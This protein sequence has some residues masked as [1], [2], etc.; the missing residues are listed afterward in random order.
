MITRRLSRLFLTLLVGICLYLLLDGSAS[1]CAETFLAEETVTLK[2]ITR[3]MLLFRTQTPDR[4]LPAP[5]QHTDVSM[6]VTGPIVRAVV[7]Q[8]FTNSSATWM[9]G[10]Y[11]FP[12]PD[13]AAVDHLRMQIGER[14]VEGQIQERGEAKRTYERA[15]HHGQRAALVEQDRPNL[16][17]TSVANIAPGETVA[18]TIEYQDTLRPD[19]DT[20]RLRFPMVV[21]PRYIPG[22]PLTPGQSTGNE[23]APAHGLGWTMNTDQVPDA[24][25]VTPPVSPPWEGAINPVRLTIDLAPGFDMDSPI[26]TYHP[27]QADSRESNRWQIRLADGTVPADRDFEL[28]WRP[29]VRTTPTPAMY[30]ENAPDAAYGLMLLTPPSDPGPA[31]SAMPREIIFVIDTSGSMHGASLA[32]AQAALRLALARLAPEDRFN[33]VQFNSVTHRLFREART[34]TPR[35]IAQ[36]LD[37]V[38]GL[39][40]TGGTEML[41]ALTLALDGSAHHDRL[42]QVVFMTDGQAGNEPELFR[43]IQERLGDSRLFTVGIGSAPNSYFMRQAAEFGRGTFTYIGKLDEVQEKMDGLFRKLE[44]P[45]VTDLRIDSAGWQ[46][47]DF[48]PARLPDV[49]DGEP[50]V[51]AVRASAIP[52]RIIL[53]GTRNGQPWRSE[54]SLANAESRPGLS[55]FWARRK[56]HELSERLDHGADQDELR[57]EILTLALRHHLVSRLTSLV[58]VDVTPARPT[59]ESLRTGAVPTHLPHGQDYQ[60]LFGLPQTATPARLHL[61]LGA[62]F[63]LLALGVGTWRCRIPS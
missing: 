6:T 61:A 4:F 9:E 30:W 40:A 54:L 3:G 49:Y 25:R 39:A 14:L 53:T 33:L 10:L 29:A 44:R 56:I 20:F 11:V 1:A 50:L 45:A 22:Q 32:Q 28:V 12:L 26:S 17:T 21:G 38:T 58:A 24:S 15:K 51:L 31:P 52:A 5:L 13:Q 59:A 23:E 37:Y 55:V 16:F 19:G 35:A 36:A 2:Q 7:T 41:P 43:I 42:R 48:L 27:I 18:V 62:A 63:H 60:A 8:R 47:A 46:D 34:A 57:H